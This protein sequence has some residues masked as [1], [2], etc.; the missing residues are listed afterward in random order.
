[1]AIKVTN[2]AVARLAGAIDETDTIISVTPGG[3]ARFP[4][5]TNANEWFP[6]TITR[7]FG[8]QEIIACTA[9]DGDILTVKRGQEDTQALSFHAGDI[10]DL[11]LTAGAFEAI[12]QEMFDELTEYGLQLATLL[13]PGSGPIPWS[14]KSEP[15]GWIF[16]DGRALAADTA[17]PNLRAAYI[18]DG[19]PYGQDAGGN[20]RIPDMRGRVV[21]GRDDMSGTAAGRIGTFM[22][23]TALGS[24]GGAEG[25][26]ITIAHLPPHTHTGTIQPAGSHTH[27]GTTDTEAAHTHTGNAA[28]GGAHTHTLATRLW[29]ANGESGGG[30]SLPVYN[31]SDTLT[32]SS[33]GAHTHTLSV[34]SAGSHSHTVTA[35]SGGDHTHAITNSSVGGGSAHSCLQP[36]MVVNYIIKT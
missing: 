25:H 16:A 23:G 36:S 1:M 2:N 14:R 32:T 35:A 21:V 7:E 28:S 18:N 3:G 17:Y 19:F 4:E 10:I 29:N 30:F 24:T 9:R 6:A 27:T 5:L 11:R 31:G 20:P 22:T 34:S 26:S 12:K 33:S 13:P 8:Q 15:A